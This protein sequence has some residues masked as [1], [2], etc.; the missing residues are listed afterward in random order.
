MVDFIVFL[1]AQI[2]NVIE[3]LNGVLLIKET[4]NESFDIGGPDI[5]TYKEMLLR[6]A[7]V[8]GL[9]RIVFPI[10]V[11]A[12]QL[13]SIWLYFVTSTSFTLAKSLVTS[14]RNRNI[15]SKI[16]EPH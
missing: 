16:L 8:R 15:I 11:M 9:T 4:F 13:S 2:R 6:F 7:K 14:L 3:Y 5:L 12:P 1:C 10:P